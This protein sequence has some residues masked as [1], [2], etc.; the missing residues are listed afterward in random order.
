ME[1]KE[2]FSQQKVFAVATASKKGIPNV[3]PVAMVQ[4]IPDDTIWIGDNYMV[5]TLSNVKE[6]PHLALYA[7]DPE[8]RR[9]F[10]IKGTVTVK[11]SGAEYEKIKARIKEKGPH[12]PAKGIL[13]VSITE[14]YECT[15]GSAAGEKIL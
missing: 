1:I 12:Y 2:V 10:Q 15:P 7:W 5:K 3:A 13:I 4:L 14:V 9:C 8:K 11:T 6:N